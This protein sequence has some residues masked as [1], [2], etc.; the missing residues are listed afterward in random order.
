MVGIEI[1]HNLKTANIDIKMDVSLF[2]VRG[3]SFPHLDFWMHF[4]YLKPHKF[5]NPFTL[6]TV[7]HIKEIK[8]SVLLI[9]NH[10]R[11]TDNHTI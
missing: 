5:A 11:T 6:N 8:M 2:K 7:F 4:F 9:Y 1:F 3:A 10:N